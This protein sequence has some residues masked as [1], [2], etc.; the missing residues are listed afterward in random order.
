MNERLNKGKYMN[1]SIIIKEKQKK[2]I[3]KDYLLLVATWNE[4]I[5]GSKFSFRLEFDV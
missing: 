1:K 2:E 5:S 3:K 4:T